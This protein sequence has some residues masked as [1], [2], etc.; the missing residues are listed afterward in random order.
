LNIKNGTVNDGTRINCA[1]NIV[2]N[3]KSGTVNDGTRINCAKNI[4]LNIKS[5][6]VND[7]T[8]INCKKDL[9]TCPQNTERILSDQMVV[10]FT[11]TCVIN[12]YHH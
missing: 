10:G 9:V 4:V 7:G 6:T 3:I 12:A 8:I 2:L 5:G 11:T 1:K